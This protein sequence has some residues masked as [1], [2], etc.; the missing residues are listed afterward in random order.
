MDRTLNLPCGMNTCPPGTDPS[1]PL[2]GRCYK[3]Q[4]M[5]EFDREPSRVLAETVTD[6]DLAAAALANDFR[7]ID[8]LDAASELLAARGLTGSADDPAGWPAETPA[9]IGGFTYAVVDDSPAARL[10]AA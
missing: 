4:D 1:T 7:S 8:T 6:R 5:A 3:H 9:V 10:A 2:A